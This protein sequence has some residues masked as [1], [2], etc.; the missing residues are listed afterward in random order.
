[1]HTILQNGGYILD[2]LQ[3]TVLVWIWTENVGFSGGCEGR[4]HYLSLACGAN[5]ERKT[6][7]SN[8]KETA[9]SRC[10]T[11]MKPLLDE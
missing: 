9:F 4:P 11:G 5:G 1:M 3:T 8:V 10:L 7:T 2:S 6:L